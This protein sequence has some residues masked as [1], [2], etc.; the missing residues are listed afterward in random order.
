MH[1]DD[2]SKEIQFNMKQSRILAFYWR[3]RKN[4][5]GKQNP[6]DAFVYVS[7]DVYGWNQIWVAF[8]ATI[9]LAVVNLQQSF[10]TTLHIVWVQH[11]PI[12]LL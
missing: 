1:S 5:Q 3:G 9:S 10:C 2:A 11:N 6:H 7:T 12:K 4:T 8:I